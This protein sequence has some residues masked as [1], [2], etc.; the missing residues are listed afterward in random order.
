MDQEDSVPPMRLRPGAYEAELM[1]AQ[2]SNGVPVDLS[3]LNDGGDAVRAPR[4]EGRKVAT[5]PQP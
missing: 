1:W 2:Q 5:Q 4:P 3:L